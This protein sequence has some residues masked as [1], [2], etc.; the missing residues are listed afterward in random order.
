M[1]VNINQLSIISH[2]SLDVNF[3]KFLPPTAT[4]TNTKKI[5]RVSVSEAVAILHEKKNS[6]NQIRSELLVK[7]RCFSFL[8]PSTVMWYTFP[9]HA[10]VM[11]A[12]RLLL[13]STVTPRA[14]P[15]DTL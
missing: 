13:P 2:F 7:S 3:V 9:L 5:H 14:H 12:D 15:K 1:Y 4:K 10:Q 11:S 8:H 6:R